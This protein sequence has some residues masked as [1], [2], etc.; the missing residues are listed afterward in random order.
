MSRIIMF[1]CVAAAVIPSQVDL[2]LI[3]DYFSWMN[4]LINPDHILLS[5]F[6]FLIEA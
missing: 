4:Q 2:Q 5:W 1:N 6:S 3:P